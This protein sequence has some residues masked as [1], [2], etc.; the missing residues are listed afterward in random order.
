[1]S[2]RVMS[3][4]GLLGISMVLLLASSADA[5]TI[6]GYGFKT[7]GVLCLE[8]AKAVSGN[9]IKIGATGTS[10]KVE[11][12]TSAIFF[13]TNKPDSGFFQGQ[14]AFNIVEFGTGFQDSSD[15]TCDRAKGRCD[16]AIPINADSSVIGQPND[17][18][19]NDNWTVVDVVPIHFTGTLELV[20][21]V[22]TNGKVTA[23]DS[24][25]DGQI[26][27]EVTVLTRDTV[28]ATCDLP[29][30]QTLQFGQ[31]R[32]YDCTTN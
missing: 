3:M 9:E 5:G 23:C 25:N 31:S 16:F 13:C 2:Q 21:C 28:S 6:A 10:C 7:K 27:P 19:P 32:D 22:N 18:C 8:T 14:A 30:P 24:D 29:N 26:D 17:A 20:T 1:M 11:D 15:A 12:V 4:I